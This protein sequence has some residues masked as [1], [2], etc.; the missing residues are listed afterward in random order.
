MTQWFH[1]NGT[2]YTGKLDCVDA[3]KGSAVFHY[4]SYRNCTL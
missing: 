1:R 4:Q 3:A 2:E